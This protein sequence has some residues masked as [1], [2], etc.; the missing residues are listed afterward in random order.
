MP[1]NEMTGQQRAV[2]VVELLR[3]RP[4]KAA[5]LAA[6]V[7]VTKQRMHQLLEILSASDGETI[8]NY[9]GYWY[10]LSENELTSLQRLYHRLRTDLDATPVGSLILGGGALRR[11][12]ADL[13][14]KVLRRLIVPPE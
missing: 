12:D 4:H 6:E 8:T 1:T 11:R 3:K 10:L 13:L 7:G 9:G 2:R 5:E 14:V